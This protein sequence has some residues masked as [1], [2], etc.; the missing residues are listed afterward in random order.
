[1]NKKD[2]CAEME[3]IREERRGNRTADQAQRLV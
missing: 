2:L 1:M 3:I